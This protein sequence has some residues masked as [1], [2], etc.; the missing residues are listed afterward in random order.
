MDLNVNVSRDDDPQTKG[1][2]SHLTFSSISSSS[3]TSSSFFTFSPSL[4]V[5]DETGCI[6]VTLVRLL[7]SSYPRYYCF[8]LLFFF[9]TRPHPLCYNHRTWSSKIRKWKT[10]NVSLPLEA[11]TGLVHL[12]RHNHEDIN[13]LPAHRRKLS[14]IHCSIHSFIL[15]FQRNRNIQTI[16]FSDSIPSLFFGWSTSSDFWVLK[17]RPALFDW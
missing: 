12:Q 15:Y 16:R 13:G 10:T 3:S 2:R 7:S 9:R 6:W 1:P 4:P 11:A 17:I 5:L 8:V 14:F